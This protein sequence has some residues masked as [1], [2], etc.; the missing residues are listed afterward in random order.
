MLTIADNRVRILSQL[1]T[2]TYLGGDSDLRKD[3]I[4]NS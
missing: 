2:N 3:H 4:S 1:L